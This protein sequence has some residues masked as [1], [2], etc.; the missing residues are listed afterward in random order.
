MP[1]SFTSLTGAQ[2]ATLKGSMASLN[3]TSDMSGLHFAILES[4]GMLTMRRGAL[5]CSTG[6]GEGVA[7]ANASIANGGHYLIR[8]SYKGASCVPEM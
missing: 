2:M 4:D 5:S 6:K 7:Q 1:G 3:I 8:V